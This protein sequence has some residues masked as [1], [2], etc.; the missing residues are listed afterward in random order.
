MNA[1]VSFIT[2]VC[3]AALLF[4]LLLLFVP[5]EGA[6]RAVR[7][8]AAA[9][10]TLVLLKGVTGLVSSLDGVRFPS[11]QTDVSDAAA[12]TD[13]VSTRFTR[14]ALADAAAD[15]L[16]SCG[17]RFTRVEASLSYGDGGFRD[18]ALTVT[19]EDETDETGVREALAPWQIPVTVERE[20]EDEGEP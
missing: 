5:E 18:V 4:S 8:A 20:G 17:C 13:A 10:L 15:R 2:A 6:G 9:F 12:Q 7:T 16:T 11:R 14:Q 19:V 1:A 3:A